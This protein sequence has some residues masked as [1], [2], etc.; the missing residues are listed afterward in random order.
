ML[1][2]TLVSLLCRLLVGILVEVSETDA[3]EI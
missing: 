3:L 2:D 1:Y